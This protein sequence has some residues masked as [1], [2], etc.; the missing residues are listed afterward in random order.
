MEIRGEEYSPL[1]SF[2]MVK[3]NHISKHY[4]DGKKV[5]TGLNDVTLSFGVDEF[6][7]VTGSSGSGKSTLLN[8]LSGTDYATS[9]QYLV[10]DIDTDSFDENDWSNFRCRNIGIIYQDNKLI[11][12][13]TVKENIEA[14]IALCCSN[15]KERKKKINQILKDTGLATLASK[16]VKYLSGGQKQRVAI[17]RAI[18][19]DCR[20]LLADEPTANLD[21]NSWDIIINKCSNYS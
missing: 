12:N 20:I 7:V 16:K 4:I 15:N 18:S 14:A 9:G 6:V 13:Y 1:N 11:E 5:V 19:K 3:L 2:Y 17:A 21:I 8:I 10:D